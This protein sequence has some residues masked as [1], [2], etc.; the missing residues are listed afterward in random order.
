MRHKWL[1]TILLVGVFFIKSTMSAEAVV[2]NGF[3]QG[4]GKQLS[5]EQVAR[6]FSL[7]D[8]VFFGEYHD[9]TWT[10]EQ[11]LAVLKALYA[12]KP[13]LILSLEMFERDVQSYLDDY[14]AKRIT[15]K[16]FLDNSRPWKN[17][18]KDYKP[19]VDFAKANKIA[20]LGGNI[21]RYMAAEYAKI[22]SLDS[23]E[24]NKKKYLPQK[25]IV[26]RDAYYTAFVGYMKSEQAGMKL[27]DAKIDRYY[28]AQSLKDDAM[29]ESIVE[30]LQKHPGK[31]LLHLQ[32]EF[33][34]RNRLGVV[35]K[36]RLLNPNL[37]TGVITSVYVSSEEEKSL[38]VRKLATGD[39]ALIIRKD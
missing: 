35:E 21:P 4:N 26:N 32:G 27:D 9:D 20:V 22:G 8:V 6:H 2:Q 16:D 29:A 25:H 34:S 13:N 11:E 23:V 7:Y 19:C 17:Y 14:L 18:G 38:A 3:Y 36:V 33:H 31:R 39:I 12:A 24:E 37:R 10:H 15:E 30:A 5:V 1:G 28:Q